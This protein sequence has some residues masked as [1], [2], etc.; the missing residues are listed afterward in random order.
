MLRKPYQ[1]SELNLHAAPSTVWILVAAEDFEKASYLLNLI[2]YN[3]LQTSVT[4]P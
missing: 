3:L 1:E 4:A 2:V